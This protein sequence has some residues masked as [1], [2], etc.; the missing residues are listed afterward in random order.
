MK[1]LLD[2]HV[3]LWALTDSAKLVAG[4]VKRTSIL[5]MTFLSV[6]PVCGRLRFSSS[7]GN[8]PCPRMYLNFS[9]A[10]ILLRC[11]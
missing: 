9:Q 3:L 5:I 10:R 8:Y 11:P 7:L 1:L 2:T 4:Y 6:L